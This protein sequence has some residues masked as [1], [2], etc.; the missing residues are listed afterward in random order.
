MVTA[1]FD[2]TLDSQFYLF[3]DY[4]QLFCTCNIMQLMHINCLSAV[5]TVE[6]CSFTVNLFLTTKCIT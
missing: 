5:K 4:V 1:N 2:E 6:L 3:T